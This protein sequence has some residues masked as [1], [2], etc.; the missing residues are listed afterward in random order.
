MAQ[1]I[2][3]RPRESTNSDHTRSCD[4]VTRGMAEPIQRASTGC[5]D[6][7]YVKQRQC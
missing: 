2:A 3:R 4:N 5:A 6:N 7:G 1:A